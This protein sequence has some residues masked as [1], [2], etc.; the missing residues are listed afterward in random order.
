MKLIATI[1]LG[2]LIAGCDQAYAASFGMTQAVQHN[3]TSQYLV[4]KNAASGTD[5]Q[6]F[7]RQ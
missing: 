1:A 4:A 5:F 2:L 3:I 6:Y 7:T